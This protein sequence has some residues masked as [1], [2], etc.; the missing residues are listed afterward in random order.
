MGID[1]KATPTLCDEMKRLSVE[2]WERIGFARTRSGLK[3]YETTITQNLLYSLQK[4]SEFSKTTAEVQMFEAI[5]EARNGNDIEIFLQVGKSYIY[6]PAQA[7]ILY[8][9]EKYPAMEHGDQIRDLINYAKSKHGYPLYLLYNF[10]KSAP[11]SHKRYGCTLVAADYLYNTFAYKTKKKKWIIP[12]YT[13]LHPDIGEPWEILACDK[14][15]KIDELFLTSLKREL[16]P[17]NCGNIKEYTLDEVLH[18]P[19][20]EK[21][22]LSREPEYRYPINAEEGPD[23]DGNLGFAPKFRIVISPER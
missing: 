23:K 19:S 18:H 7:K 3:I 15:N 17:E 21:L 9:N 13:D 1:T 20:W 14:L 5:N 6:L 4:F 12:S 22:S 10:A 8:K 2:T 16:V 11:V